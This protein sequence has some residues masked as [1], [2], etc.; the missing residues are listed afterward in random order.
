MDYPVGRT[1]TGE[2]GDGLIR[3]AQ[4][5]HRDGNVGLVT[6]SEDLY[7][8]NPRP[9]PFFN[10]ANGIGMNINAAF[11]GTPLIVCNGS[12][13]SPADWAFS[14]VIGSKASDEN[15]DQANSGSNSVHWNNGSLNDVIEFDNGSD[16]TVSSYVAISLAI[17]VDKD[18]SGNDE[19]SMY[20]WDDTSSTIVGNSVD[21]SGFFNFDVFDTW[22]QFSVGFD[23]LGL[24]EGT[25]DAVRFEITAKSGPAP[26]IYLDD[27]QVENTGGT[28]E[29]R[30]TKDPAKDYYV[31]S[32][33]FTIVDVFG[34]TL[35]NGTMPA[36][37]FDQILGQAALSNGIIFRRIQDGAVSFSVTLKQ[38]SDFFLNGS[39]LTNVISDGTDTLINITVPFFNPVILQGGAEDNFMSLTI[40]E[41]LR[42]FT[43][44]SAVARGS[45]KEN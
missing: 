12:E 34:G 17:Y 10:S 30:V 45:D 1:V 44:L 15:T 38:L 21:L 32:I 41:D 26:K 22:H 36:L 6:L 2:D 8:F 13:S 14:Q 25:F 28:V 19:I 37:S 27:V 7:I 9:R 33:I 39:V 20:A 42:G 4:V 3:D 18:W 35:S 11:G 29:Y 16:V 40:S 5:H 24:N 43:I 23:E 31:N